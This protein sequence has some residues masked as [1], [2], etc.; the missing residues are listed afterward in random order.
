MPVLNLT[1]SK[2]AAVWALIKARLQADTALAGCGL[3]LLFLDG[4]TESLADLESYASTG[5]IRFAPRFGT[6]AWN[7]ET[8]TKVA[9]QVSVQAIIPQAD[10]IDHLNLQS[11]IDDAIQP[12]ADATYQ[13]ALIS[14][15][16]ETGL[17]VFVNP[18]NP[19]ANPVGK[20]NVMRLQGSFLVDVTKQLI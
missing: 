20:D 15:G 7:Y 13:D 11:A 19:I 18:L 17:V 16:A 8:A 3:A 6:L 14:A 1:T 5:A 4:Q 10:S 12:L 2:Y 9:L